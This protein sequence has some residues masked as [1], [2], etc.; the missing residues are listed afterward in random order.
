MN[1]STRLICFGDSW[2]MGHGVEDD[3]KFKEI[4]HPSDGVD[5]TFRERMCNGWSRWLAEKLNCEFI[6]IGWC[7][8][9][10]LD[11]SKNIQMVLQNNLL[12]ESDIII[13]M[14][15]YPYRDDVGPI[16]NF[17][18]IENMLKSYKHFYFNSFYPTFKNEEFDTAKLPEY[19]INP[20]NCVSDILRDYE[21]ANDISVWEYNSRSVWNDEKN[22]YEGD[23][24]PNLLGYKLIGEHIYEKIKSYIN[25]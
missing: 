7:G 22:F 8:G 20:N 17:N 18:E 16:Q 5:F 10:N 4:A 23:Y 19:F 15:S 11:I 21:I 13:V 9:N 24:H 12:K 1:K 2:T 25:G 14:F 3:V 6:P